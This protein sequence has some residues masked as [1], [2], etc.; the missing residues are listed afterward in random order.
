MRIGMTN[1]IHWL[2]QRRWLN[3][4]FVLA[5][6]LLVVLPHEQV[7]LL[8]A[9]AFKKH[10]RDT[11]NFVILVV[12]IL[13]LAIYSVPVVKNIFKGKHKS[14]KLFYL[15]VTLLL[16]ILSINTLMVV[17][18]EIIH[19]VQYALMAILLFP[20]IGNYGETLFWTTFLGAIDEAYQYFYLSPERT[21]YYDFNDVIINLL[22]GALGLILL[23]CLDIGIHNPFRKIHIGRPLMAIGA[24]LVIISVLW[25]TGI[26]GFY[27][28]DQ[29]APLFLLVRVPATDFWSVVHPQVTYHVVRPL[30]GVIAI[31]VLLVFYSNLGK[32]DKT[33]NR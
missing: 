18:V 11:Y 17:N 32:T 10:S 28:Q 24:L 6:F 27:P 30:E 9:E 23:R 16:I 5:F 13:G 7:G 3:L 1:F 26:L 21:D 19:F 20:L 25:A 12:G 15:I 14:L 33:S 4:F 22:G 2:Q 31:A 29:H 8:I